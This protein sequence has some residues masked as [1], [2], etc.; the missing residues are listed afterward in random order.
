MTRPGGAPAP[1]GRRGR[2]ARWI[3][4][5]T[6]LLSILA[7]VSACGPFEGD[8]IS[9]TAYFT[10]SVGLF[11]GN[12][13]DVL[14]VP[15][16]EVESVTPHGDRVAVRMR[17]P[18]D[19]PVPAGAGALIIPPTV[20]TDRYVELT[21]AY[22]TGP[23]I[24]DGAVIPLERTRTPVE[25]DRI[26]RAIDQLAV[27]LN[28]DSATT[29]AIRDALGVA[30]ENLDGNGT[31]IRRSIQGLSAAVAALDE[32]RD[33]LTGLI[34][35]LDTLTETFARNDGTIRA[36]SRDVTRATG[37]L[38]SNGPDL[39]ATIDALTTALTEVGAFVKENKGAAHTGIVS[40]RAVLATVN[41][42]RTEL[43]EAVDVLPLTFQNLTRMVDPTTRRV[44]ANASAAA[45]LLNP[46]IMDQICSGLGI[47]PCPAVP[48]GPRG[49]LG[50]VLP[51]RSR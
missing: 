3:G 2:G 35:S 31:R 15:V 6:A 11:E 10:D 27:S 16:G 4:A 26:I 22:T 50:D 12:H 33:D 13:V 48:R 7:G 1:R 39:D 45:N 29:G 21:P 18:A 44:R 19:M 40:L 51:R 25:F 30:A 42:H 28:K 49:A 38:A 8:T 5:L 24:A 34:R 32:N 46:V 9:V 36:F 23:R 20:I 41:K 43:T 37:V 14:G 17:I 47:S